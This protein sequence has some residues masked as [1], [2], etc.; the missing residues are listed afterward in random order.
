MHA[1]GRRVLTRRGLAATLLA[2]GMAD[3]AQ[4]ATREVAYFVPQNQGSADA[5]LVSWQGRNRAR[6]VRGE[7]A[8]TGSVLDDGVQKLVTLDAPLSLQYVAAGLDSC[9]WQPT[10]RHDLLQ[11]VYRTVSGT[12]RRGS[13]QIVD[14][15]TDT[16]LD[17]CDAGQVTP[18][19]SPSD[20]GYTEAYLAMSERP[21]VSD[22][23]AGV[24][25]AGLS[26]GV[27]GGPGQPPAADLTTLL[28]G[29]QLR[30]E[31]TGHTLPYTLTPD[32]WFVAEAVG[33]AR[34]YTRLQVDA[35]TGSEL[36]LAAD[37]AGGLP[38]NLWSAW[39][40]KPTAGA[41]FGTVNQASR[42]WESGL[43]SGTRQ[44]FY[45]YLYNDQTGERVSKDLDEGTESRTPLPHWEIDGNVLVQVR[46]AGNN[47]R[48]RT[49]RPVATSGKHH[50][51]LE[52]EDTVF[53]D[54]SRSPLILP[55][56]NDYLDTGKAVQLAAGP[57]R[58]ARPQ[59]A[60]RSVSA[61]SLSR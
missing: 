60:Q 41:S 37:F 17:G 45:I 40:V 28:P 20:A 8:A 47:Q 9:G 61:G 5:H 34:G 10:I 25:L 44:P 32:L 12:S 57:R 19:G 51:V 18:F 54:G 31:A 15:G 16:V 2:L 4:S 39:G 23:V 27:F 42:M 59:Q 6:V 33:L 48:V 29:Q 1:F 13:A 52:A 14:I 55:R 49:W 22:L 21:A 3:A 38:Q 35:R 30:F 53:P 7:G 46:A 36:W 26:E 11:V 58:A 50:F 43:F 24:Q 56:V